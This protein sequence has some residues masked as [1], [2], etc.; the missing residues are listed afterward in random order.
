MIAGRRVLGLI[1]ARGGSQGLPGKN[2]RSL[3][4]KPLIVWTIDTA[5][6]SSVLDRTILSTDS[7]AIAAVA[8]AAGCDVP[9]QRPSSLAQDRTT[10]AAVVE[11]ALE[12]LDDAGDRYDL[13][14][15]LQPTSPL[16]TAGDIDGAVRLC[17]DRDATT[18]VSVSPSRQNPYWMITIDEFGTAR[19]LFP[20]TVPTRRQDLPATYAYNGAL[21]VVRTEWIRREKQIFA[22]HMV[23]Y[24]MPFER[25]VDIDDEADFQ[26]AELAARRIIAQASSSC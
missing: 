23:A 16:R 17:V 13:V 18:C 15:L 26:L 9:F 4:G 25:S 22:P 1:V 6:A 14:V 3:A 8:R 24:V 20:A 21:Y 5:L 11:H 19:P 10:S 12:V 7:A 2:I